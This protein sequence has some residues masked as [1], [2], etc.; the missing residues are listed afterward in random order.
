MP[1]ISAL[2][3]MLFAHNI[4]RLIEHIAMFAAMLEED[5]D[6]YGKEF[7]KQILLNHPGNARF[8]FMD[9]LDPYHAYY[10]EP[11]AVKKASSKYS[12]SAAPAA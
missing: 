8:S 10:R 12:Y 9:A 1:I 4:R 11:V 2:S 6:K 7:K 3:L 5:W